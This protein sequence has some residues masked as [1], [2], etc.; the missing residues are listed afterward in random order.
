LVKSRAIN[1]VGTFFA[2]IALTV[3]QTG[4]GKKKMELKVLALM[5]LMAAIIGAAHVV[6]RS[7]KPATA[8]IRS[9]TDASK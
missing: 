7:G 8:R 1:G 6:E 2:G 9:N 4:N 5:A 3:H